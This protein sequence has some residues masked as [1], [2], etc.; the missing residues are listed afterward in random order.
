MSVIR[1]IVGRSGSG[2]DFIGNILSRDLGIPMLVTYTTREM[3]KGEI[4]GKEHWF[5]N[6]EQMD[7]IKNNKQ[8]IAY[9]KI[10]E[11]EYCGLYEDVVDKDVIYIINP[12]GIKYIKE[13]FKDLELKIIYV[14]ANEKTREQRVKNRS[15]YESSYKK[16]CE[17]EDEEFKEFE[18]NQEW[19][20]IIENSI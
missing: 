19:D 13:H 9:T 20:Y 7:Y 2:K 8:M 17:N 3:R 1:C 11:V 6:K 10:G 16:R 5:I 15:D 12:N 14:Y 4:N 18:E